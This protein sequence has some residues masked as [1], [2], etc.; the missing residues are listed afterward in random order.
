MYLV[1]MDLPSEFNRIFPFDY[2]SNEEKKE[3]TT[4][5]INRCR[6]MFSKDKMKLKYYKS[7]MDYVNQ[8]QYE[9][10]KIADEHEKT[11]LKELII[12]KL[13]N[14]KDQI[15]IDDTIEDGK[16]NILTMNVYPFLFLIEHKVPFIK[17]SVA[18]HELFDL[19][20]P[21]E[22]IDFCFDSVV[23]GPN[24]TRDKID[25]FYYNVE[26][27]LEKFVFC[28]EEYLNVNIVCVSNHWNLQEQSKILVSASVTN[29]RYLPE[30]ETLIIFNNEQRWYN[31]NYMDLTTKEE[32]SYE[33]LGNP[34][35]NR[36][37]RLIS[38]EIEKV[39]RNELVVL[40]EPTDIGRELPKIEISVRE[41]TYQFLVGSTYNLYLPGNPGKSSILVGKID[42]INISSE[43]RNGK[44]NIKWIEGYP[45]LLP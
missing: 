19:P 31:V 35:T 42:I 20:K 6:N 25:E 33:E 1:Y 18:F 45:D 38:M 34:H 43:K 24:I 15:N 14:E 12:E 4:E 11:I 26:N 23:F 2:L 7:M 13:Q 37:K 28:L 36:L 16:L 9:N 8:E 22:F 29:R 17:D 3:F 40:Y 44:A 10:I 27:H 30:R 39:N 32:N 41:K 21:N 5:F